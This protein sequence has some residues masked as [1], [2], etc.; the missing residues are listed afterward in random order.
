MLK[1]AP[2]SPQKKRLLHELSR[3]ADMPEFF[4]KLGY[5]VLFDAGWGK[6]VEIQGAGRTDR[7]ISEEEMPT[8]IVELLHIPG[9][10]V[11][12]NLAGHQIMLI[13]RKGANRCGCNR[14]LAP[15]GVDKRSLWE[16]HRAFCQ[17]SNTFPIPAI[18][19]LNQAPFYQVDPP[20]DFCD[21]RARTGE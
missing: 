13:N 3:W 11:A 16:R 1:D 20:A 15:G 12:I 10:S 21:T 8:L 18:T 9:E 4:V 14:F 7:F 5:F 19:L 6:I 2:T 17:Y